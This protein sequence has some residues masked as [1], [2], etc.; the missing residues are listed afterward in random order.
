MS[1]AA[2][3]PTKPTLAELERAAVHEAKGIF[4]GKDE[5]RC[6]TCRK[7]AAWEARAS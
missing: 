4:S 1:A 7:V 3:K 6:R 5:C 2:Q